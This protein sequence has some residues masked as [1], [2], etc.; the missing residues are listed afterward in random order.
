MI[1]INAEM[2][3]PMIRIEYQQRSNFVK[4]SSVFTWK[5]GE[6][7]EKNSTW[8]IFGNQRW[9]FNEWFNNWFRLW[10]G[11]WFRLRFWLRLWFVFWLRLWFSKNL[12]N[13]NISSEIN[14]D[15][16]CKLVSSN[17]RI[18]IWFHWFAHLFRPHH[19]RWFFLRSSQRLPVPLFVRRLIFFWLWL[20]FGSIFTLGRN[21]YH[22]RAINNWSDIKRREKM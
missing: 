21:K 5:I 2:M 7:N 14:F 16:I 22:S 9:H 18:G 17:K 1:E 3:S 11:R 8:N 12:G 19:R 4:V 6:K 20:R 13:W 15:H 10:F